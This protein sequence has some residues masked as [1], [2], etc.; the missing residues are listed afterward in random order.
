L[1]T[2]R[3][4]ECRD[5]LRIDMRLRDGLPSIIDVNANPSLASNG[6]VMRAAQ[7]I[8]LPLTRIVENLLRCALERT[9]ALPSSLN[10]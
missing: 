1:R 3:L 5:Y 9:P 10:N 4:L 6:S 8:R 2:S 7:A